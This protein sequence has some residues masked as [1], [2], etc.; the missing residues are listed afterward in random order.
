MGNSW[1]GECESPPGGKAPPAYT[2]V[3]RRTHTLSMSRKNEQPT[4]SDR[5]VCSSAAD[6]PGQRIF[7]DAD[8]ECGLLIS[9]EESVWLQECHM[10]V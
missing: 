7:A 4:A 10:A 8:F 2:G 9:T 6:V 5:R 3:F 1:E